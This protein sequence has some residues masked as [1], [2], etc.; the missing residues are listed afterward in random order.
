[1][2]KLKTIVSS[3]YFFVAIV[4]YYSLFY[5]LFGEQYPFKA[6]FSTDGRVYES[7]VFSFSQSYYFDSYYIHRILPSLIIRISF[8]LFSIDMTEANILFAFQILN[9]VSLVISSY[10]LKKI[11]LIL[12]ISLKSQLLFFIMF[13][14]NFGVIKYQFY[15]PSMTDQL[16]LMLS[17]LLLYFYLRNNV[18]G[19]VISTIA[20]AFTWPM[21][22]YLGLILIALPFAVLPYSQASKLQKKAVYSISVLYILI[23]STI[24]VFILNLDI[25]VAFVAKIDRGWLALPLSIAGIATIYFFFGKLFLNKA[26]FN[27]L[28]FIKK[29]DYKR[30]AISGIVFITVYLIIGALHPKPTFLYSISQTLI[31]PVLYSFIK[32]LITIV[33]DVSYFGVLICLLI[34]FW[35]SFCKIASQMGWGIVIAMG[36][37]LFLFG[38]APQSR[39]LIN[40]L[41]WLIVILAK[42]LDKYSFP[43]HFYIIVGILSIIASK[44]WLPLNIYDYYKTMAPTDENG[45]IGFPD[46]IL[47]MNIGP[48]MDTQMYYVQGIAALVIMAIFFLMLYKIEINKS[49][50]IRLMRKF[51][52]K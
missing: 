25:K 2:N 12:K 42:A 22:Y 51:H 5:V 10:F 21:A 41:P 19:L 7:I 37:N 39:H 11:F 30:L 16:A 3:N 31:D 24:I 27:V 33:A 15:F 47:W 40:L 48:W 9:I 4:L 6:G 26:L 14:F 45:N 29:I 38:L 43:N 8:N 46:Q 44:V 23:L 20:L 1:M 18:A 35:N 13:L 17:T 28:L 50:R 32:P 36:L 52:V 49:N 34:L